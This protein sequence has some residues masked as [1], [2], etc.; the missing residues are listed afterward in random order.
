MHVHQKTMPSCWSWQRG[1]CARLPSFL[2]KD[3]TL[4]L[5][6]VTKLA[7]FFFFWKRK[8]SK[9]E[10][11]FWGR[12]LKE[13]KSFLVPPGWSSFPSHCMSSEEL[14]Y[15]VQ[16][17]S[18]IFPKRG[19]GESMGTCNKMQ[20]QWS[21]SSDHISRRKPFEVQPSFPPNPLVPSLCPSWASPS[22]IFG[23]SPASASSLYLLMVAM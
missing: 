16:P 15:E 9:W 14:W 23:S 22:L 19:R 2:E 21:F 17:A 20:L 12:S 11:F 8:A 13:L 5:C 3:G 6:I 1:Y 7:F 18:W 10:T 4:S